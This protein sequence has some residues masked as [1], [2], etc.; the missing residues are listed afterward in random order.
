MAASLNDDQQFDVDLTLK[1]ELKPIRIVYRPTEI[2]KLNNFF[3]VE[4]I[5]DETKFKA[6]QKFDSLKSKLSE[7]QKNLLLQTNK[8]MNR[9]NIDI[10]C[11]VLEL[12]FSNNPQTLEESN[13]K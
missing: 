3:Y 9:I 5:K 2:E 11:P 12:P 10:T 8:K 13:G 4:N 7:H 6:Q 1:I